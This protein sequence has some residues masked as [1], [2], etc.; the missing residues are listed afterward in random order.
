[1]RYNRRMETTLRCASLAV[2]AC[3]LAFPPA[4]RALTLQEE[5][6]EFVQTYS[7]LYQGVYA[8]SSAASWAAS[9]DAGP[10]HDAG[11]VAANKALAALTGGPLVIAKTKR[12]LERAGELDPVVVRQL[13]KIWL[14]AAENPGDLPETVAKRVEA[15]SRQSTTLD[16][17]QF[18][19][20]RRGAECVRPTTANGIDELLVSTRDLS[21]RLRVWEA[22]KETGPALKP[23]LVE[24]RGL[25]NEVAR[26]FGYPSYYDLQVADYGMS[27]P[28]MTAMLDGF[29]KDIEP[30]YKELHCWTKYALAERY[31]QPVPKLIPAHWIGN[32]WSQEWPGIVEGVDLA[33]LFKDKSKEWIV[34]QAEAFYVSMGLPKLPASFWTGSDLYPVPQDSARKKNTH[35]S[36]WHMDLADD[37]RSLM[38]VEPNARWFSTAHHEL[39]H[40][41]YYLAYTRPKVP[42]LLRTG[43]N[44]S[45]HE[46]MGEL[47]NLAAMQRPYLRRIGILPAGRKIDRDRW[48]LNEAL[49]ETVAFLPWS[50]GTITAWERA[51]YAEDL[52][53]TEWNKR[54]WEYVR[55]YQG[56]EPPAARGEE[57][58]DGC[59]K[60]HVNDN[61]AYYY[62]Y[63]IATVLKYQLHERICRD[64]LKQDPHACDYSGRPE[65]G[66]FFQGLLAPGATRDWRELLREKT[67]KDLGTKPMMDYYQPLMAFLKK[68]NKGRAC[69]W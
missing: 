36:A 23:G 55:K 16:S 30:L 59:T 44:R 11:R 1:M 15:E 8:A 54:W 50:A 2:F 24:L 35:A 31:G 60:T 63:A 12:L 3:A 66:D 68:E 29:L 37:V 5:A 32:R 19:L 64:I 61:P 57:F 4:G 46:G 43:A 52:P 41:Y 56:I 25:R 34:E 9:T 51:L 17:F 40:V 62:T 38:S 47:I 21:M 48:L 49:T 18:C 13:R 69:G 10:E 67:G 26:H 39:G 45:F 53:E 42:V 14:Y 33:P 28:E 7:G 65:V 6:D 27:G 20:E 58:C 22:S